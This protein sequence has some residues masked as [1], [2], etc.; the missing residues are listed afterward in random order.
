MLVGLH[1]CGDLCSSLLRLFCSSDMIKSMCC[2]ACC[3][4]HITE[5]ECTYVTVIT[6]ATGVCI[7]YCTAPDQACGFPLSSFLQKHHCKLG[8]NARMLGCQV[9]LILCRINIF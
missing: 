5:A 8:R 9:S 1:T 6:Y 7:S 3:Y 2:V 4:H